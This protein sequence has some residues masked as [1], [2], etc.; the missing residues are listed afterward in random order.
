M[1]GHA[2]FLKTPTLMLGLASG[3]VSAF[4]VSCANPQ[5]VVAAKE[6]PK[7]DSAYVSG[8]F[9]K[10]GDPYQGNFGLGLADT[11]TN[12]EILFPMFVDHVFGGTKDG[13]VAALRILEIPAGTYQL[14]FW[15]T[16]A[17][18]KSAYK[19]IPFTGTSSRRSSRS[20]LGGS[21]T[22]ESTRC[23]TPS[24]AGPTTASSGSI[25][26]SHRKPRLPN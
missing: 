9:Y 11:T 6:A 10:S 1:F 19:V 14:K 18:D 25:A 21:P 3:L 8:I 12:K 7:A 20:S 13:R 17:G 26:S 5:E 16:W 2:R 24:L 15:A 4:L 23:G 22:S